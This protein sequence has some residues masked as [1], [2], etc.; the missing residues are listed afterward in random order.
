M[1]IINVRENR[2]GNHELIIQRH[3]QQCAQDTERKQTKQLANQN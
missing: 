2:M 3:R 1:Y